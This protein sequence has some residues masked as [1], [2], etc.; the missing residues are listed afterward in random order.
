[1]GK[2][3]ADQVLD[4]ALSVIAAADRVVALA[5]Q[6]PSYAAALNNRLAEAPM[7]PADFVI[8]QGDASG[9][10]VAI[11]GKT[12]ASVFAAGTASHVALLDTATERLLYVTTCPVQT[13][14]PGGTV[15][16]EDWAV[17]IGDPI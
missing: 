11:G 14:A 12:A 5:G 6:P 7:A 1:M 17:E 8:S 13:L 9:R 4:A 15:S 3:V 2:W 10:K 16:F